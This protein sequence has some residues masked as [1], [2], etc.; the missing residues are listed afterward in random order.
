LT[1]LAGAEGGVGD[2]AGAGGREIFFAEEVSGEGLDVGAAVTRGMKIEGEA[3]E[4]DHE[5]LEADFDA[6]VA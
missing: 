5:G 1:E 6:G 2:V 4:I 3:A